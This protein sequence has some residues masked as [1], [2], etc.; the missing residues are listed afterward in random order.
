MPGLVNVGGSWKTANA[1]SVNV[2]GSWKTV[3]SGFVN[4]NGSWKQWYSSAPPP[5]YEQIATVVANG[6]S[7]EVTFSSIPQG[8]KHLQI[9]YISR[10]QQ[11]TTRP[12]L[13]YIRPNGSYLGTGHYLLGASSSITS[14]NVTNFLNSHPAVSGTANSFG[15]GI[16]D[17]LDYTNSGKNPVLRSFSGFTNGGTLGGSGV[18]SDTPVFL[19]SNSLNSAGAVTSITITN[20]GFN[21]L[22]SGS[23]FS[24]YGIRG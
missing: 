11:N 3:S 14:G 13:L 2:N 8:Y 6:S 12:S 5:A 1:A 23:R 16:V 10:S 15:S 18:Q 21:N 4:V 9:R 7:S 17:I 20:E 22:V 24:L 19:S